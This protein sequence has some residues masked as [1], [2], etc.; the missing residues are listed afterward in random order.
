MMAAETTGIKT[1][2]KIFK[3]LVPN[4]MPQL[5]VSATLGLGGIIL[6]ESTL[7]YLGLGVPFPRAAW[8]SMIAL[9]IRQRD[10]RFLQCILICGFQQGFLL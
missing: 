8:G 5:V 3:H 1:F 2:N 6:Y 9:Q 10:K 7:S 4:T